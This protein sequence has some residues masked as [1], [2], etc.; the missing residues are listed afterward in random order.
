VAPELSLSTLVSEL[1]RRI[2]PIFMPKP[3]VALAELPRN[4]TGKLP[5]SNLQA[6]HAEYRSG[7]GGD[8]RR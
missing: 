1:R 6:L 5:R 8:E 2:D 4:A 3:I 7:V